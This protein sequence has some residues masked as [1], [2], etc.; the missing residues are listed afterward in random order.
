MLNLRAVGPR[1]HLPVRAREPVARERLPSCREP[2][3]RN[4]QTARSRTWFRDEHTRT[5][6]PSLRSRPASAVLRA[7]S[8]LAPSHSTRPCDLP[9]RQ[10]ARCVQPTSAT[11]TTLRAPAPRSFL[12]RSAAF[13]AWTSV[14]SWAP[15]DMTRG[16][17]VS[18]R[19]RT[20][21]RT[22]P[23]TLCLVPSTSRLPVTSVGVLFPRRSVSIEPLT[24]VS[25][26]PLASRGRP[27]SRALRARA[28]VGSLSR[29]GVVRELPRPPFPPP[30]ERRRFR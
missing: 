21:R 28:P 10:D 5:D 26:L 19:P 30:R 4:P 7:S 20:L 9:V 18:R 22:D 15:R 12:A 27:P 13:T 3:S 29:V 24:P 17:D 11:R 6:S 25:L 1:A 16:P 14:E 2:A 8:W 23:N